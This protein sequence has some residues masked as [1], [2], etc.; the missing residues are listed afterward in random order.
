MMLLKLAVVFACIVIVLY[1]RKPLYM[2]IGAGIAAAWVL[3]GVPVKDGL[4]TLWRGVFQEGT[5]SVLLSYY[6]V[7]FLMFLMEKRNMMKQAEHSLNSLISNRRVSLMLAMIFVGLLPSA[8][9][10]YICGA[11]LTAA[12]GEA[13]SADDKT[14]V[15]SFFRHVPE[16]FLPTFSAVLLALE[17]SG[18]SAGS[19]VLVMIPMVVWI[20]FIGY[21]FWIRKIPSF[22]EVGERLPKKKAGIQL[23]NS[24]WGI[25]AVIILIVAFDLS[26]YLSVLLVIAVMAVAYRYRI[27]ELKDVFL[28]SFQW[29]V[30]ANTIIVMVF[31][32]FLTYTNVI[33]TIPDAI[34]KLPIPMFLA[35]ALIFFLGTIISG[36]QAIIAMCIPLTFAAM[37]QGGLPLLMLVMTATYAGM[38]LSPTHVCLAMVTDYFH[39]DMGPLIKRTIPMVLLICAGMFAYYFILTAIF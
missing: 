6:L 34:S 30:I 31:K 32:E 4:A 27:T 3:Y 37:P 25:T 7:T 14:F 35:F 13:L 10:V 26:V 39:T 1:L 20:L 29:N 22:T 15:A 18:I 17:L 12:C 38:Q 5:Y 8:A 21:F 23:V 16:S 9:A 11:I 19:F 36:S 2:A 24:L 33:H 28:R